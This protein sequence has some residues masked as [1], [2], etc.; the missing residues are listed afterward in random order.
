MT[1]CTQTCSFRA[2]F[3]LLVWSLTIMRKKNFLHRCT[4]TFPALNNCS[5]IFFKSLSY[6]Y[7]V[8]CT[9]FSTDF[10]TF[11][12]FR[13]Q[14][15][16]NV[17]PPSNENENYVVYL[18]EQSI[19]KKALKIASKSTHKPS[20]NPPRAGRPSMTYKKHQFSLLQPARVVRSAPNFACW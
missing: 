13:P 8:V 12:N 14:F 2:V 10:W 5:G 17:A 7:E 15:R 11:R 6:L 18:K 4:S 20:H 3:G 16:E 19:L 1:W 9:K